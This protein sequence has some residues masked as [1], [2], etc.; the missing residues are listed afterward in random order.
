MDLIN[1]DNTIFDEISALIE[2]N[3]RLIYTQANSATVLLFWKIG[4]R[5]NVEILQSKRAEAWGL[6]QSLSSIC[7]QL[8]ECHF[9]HERL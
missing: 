2:Q 9:H 3:R 4:Q 6:G 5:V 7:P 8:E 1:H